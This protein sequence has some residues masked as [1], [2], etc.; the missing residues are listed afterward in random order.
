[1]LAL[2]AKLSAPDAN[3]YVQLLDVDDAGEETL[4]NDGFL[5]ASHRTSHT[6][7]EPAPVGQAI[8]YKIEIRAQHY[9]F[10]A[11]R[12][13]RI[14]L[15]GGAKDAVIQVPSVDV[16]IETGTHATLSLP[17]FAAAP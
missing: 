5:K 4:V 3:F 17:G 16:A 6:D 2:R 1:M 10:A 7:P 9:R 13:V 14:R 12:R 8:D 11:G 15:W